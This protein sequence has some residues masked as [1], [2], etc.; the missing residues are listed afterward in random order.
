[1]GKAIR[2]RLTRPWY[3][4]NQLWDIDTEIDIDP[5]LAPSSAIRLKTD[6]T[7]ENPRE[8]HPQPTIPPSLSDEDKE[9]LREEFRKELSAEQ[10]KLNKEQG[11]EGGSKA[12]A[13]T[14]EDLEKEPR[15]SGS[16]EE[17]E[18]KAKLAG[19]GSDTGVKLVKKD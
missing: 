19:T 11:T 12:K 9:L 3:D 15:D 18:A 14:P 8:V 13:Q 10:V 2:Y 1:M 7:P 5:D 4:G 17:L 16:K 6:G